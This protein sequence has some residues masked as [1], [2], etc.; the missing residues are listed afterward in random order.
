MHLCVVAWKRAGPPVDHC[1]LAFWVHGPSFTV[2]K[3]EKLWKP[4]A[5]FITHLVARPD[6][7]WRGVLIKSMS[8]DYSLTSLQT[9]NMLVISAAQALLGYH[10]MHSIWII[11]CILKNIWPQ[12]FQVR[13]FAFHF[14]A[15]EK[16]MAPHSSVLAWRIPETEE[17]GGLPSM[18][19]HRVGHDWSDLAAVAMCINGSVWYQNCD[20]SSVLVLMWLISSD[21]V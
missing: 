13:A 8:S 19:S 5:F 3:C 11:F 17:P 20:I 18:G 12:I 21:R 10:V 15:L 9:L 16:E 14:H 6:L 2:P 7:N 1:C 4:N